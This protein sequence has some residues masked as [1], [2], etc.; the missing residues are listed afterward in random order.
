[1]RPAIRIALIALGL[2]AALYG[3][4]SLTGGWMGT[5]PW[6]NV[7]DRKMG[8]IVID[9]RDTMM[10]NPGRLTPEEEA[11]CEFAH[12]IP[13]RPD[14]EW[15]SVDVV[16]AGVAVATLGGWPR[17]RDSVARDASGRG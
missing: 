5:P 8:R 13:P 10:S 17:R 2:A 9:D 6:W 3:I 15:I 1:M 4:A 14:R 7:S 12:P 16:V 11:A